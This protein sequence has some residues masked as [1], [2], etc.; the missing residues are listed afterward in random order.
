MAARLRLVAVL[1]VATLGASTGAAGAQGSGPQTAPDE[2]TL[3]EDTVVVVYPLLNDSDPQGGSLELVAVSSSEFGDTRIDGQAVVFTPVDDFN[4]DVELTYTAR[5]SGG[6]ADEQIFLEVTPVNDP[7]QANPDTAEATSG[8]SISIN[9]LGNDTDV[10]GQALTLDSVANPGNGTASVSGSFVVYTANDGFAG[11]DF[12]T[13][14]ISD[15]AGA[16][17]QGT[18]TVS[19]S[20]PAVTTTTTAP[21]TTT[22]AP[23]TTLP[24]TTLPATTVPAT[25]TPPATTLPATTMPPATTTPPQISTSTLVTSPA[26]AAP[27]TS[28]L[29]AGDGNEEGF[30]AILARNLSSLYLPILTLFVVG[31][32]AW[33][34]SQRGH[35]PMRRRAVVLLGRGESLPV[36][37]RPS[38][39]AGVIHNFGHSERQIEVVG[40]KREAEGQAWLPVA[41][42][43]GRG[44]AD[45]GHL[46]EDVA[47]ASFEL[48]LAEREI[49]RELRRR[50]KQGATIATSPR[51]VIDPES[52]T[53]DPERRQL[54]G[55]ATTK[56]AALIGDWR[57]AFHIDKTA[58]MAGLRPPQL[59]N[60][61]WVS[62]DAPG[63]DP[64]LLFFEYHDGN[65]HPVA[66]LPETAP[67]E[68]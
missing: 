35:S 27:P 2:A 21:P 36:Y 39:S 41:T 47:R 6:E 24:A 11:S 32:A 60:L 50:L 4:G 17:S 10:D 46:T 16:T 3:D 12:V 20:L 34:L 8:A 23:A 67:V 63:L 22:V 64:W 30:F 59:R 28:S 53:R 14:V 56:L 38:S 42:P 58:S 66:A 51:G 55:N 54:G 45:A 18:I 13:Y 68:V 48:D 26:W 40:R 33:L 19:V 61:H 65:P 37:E 52:F 49:I 31:I 29:E 43:N 25:T 5:S 1:V 44:W 62:F 15:A 57:A 9:V 7:P